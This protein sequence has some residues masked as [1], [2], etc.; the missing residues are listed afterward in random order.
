MVASA[1][2]TG[3]KPNGYYRKISRDSDIPADRLDEVI[4]AKYD[5][6]KWI[7]LILTVGLNFQR[8]TF[9]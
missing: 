8:K 9:H 2:Q 1:L 3:H 7:L 4:F 5:P 6:Q